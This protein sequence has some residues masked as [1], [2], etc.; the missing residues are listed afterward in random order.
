MDLIVKSIAAFCVGL[1]VLAG[2]RSAGLSWLTQY[3]RSDRAM[4][5]GVPAMGAVP[6]Y[7]MGSLKDGI[8]PKFPAIDTSAYQRLGVEAAARG[9]SVQVRAAQSAAS[10]PIRIP[11]L[12]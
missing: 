7:S 10:S 5:A 8:Q 2:I 4:T 3:L 9:A 12:R 6:N 11:G 1:L